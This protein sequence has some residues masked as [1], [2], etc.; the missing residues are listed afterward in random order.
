MGEGNRY[1]VKVNVHY[2]MSNG[3]PYYVYSLVDLE[4]RTQVTDFDE[5]AETIFQEAKKR[6]GEWIPPEHEGAEA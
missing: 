3:R 4:T 2:R 6:N 5:N 1:I